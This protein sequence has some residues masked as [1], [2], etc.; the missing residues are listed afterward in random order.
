MA[1]EE[2][3]DGTGNEQ[4]AIEL[5]RKEEEGDGGGEGGGAGEEQTLSAA[6]ATALRA[7]LATAQQRTEQL[8]AL[9]GD[10]DVAAVLDAKN[11]G[12]GLVLRLGEQEGEDDESAAPKLPDALEIDAM[13]PSQTVAMILKQLPALLTHAVR[14]P[15]SELSERLGALETE[16]TTERKTKLKGDVEKLITRYPDFMTHKD[17]IEKLCSESGLTLN[18]AYIVARQ[19]SGKGFPEAAG[20]GSERPTAI[21]VRTPKKVAPARLGARGFKIDLREVLDGIEEPA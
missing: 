18:E 2:T 9:V 4:R 17:T 20:A 5:E 10:P 16:R 8:S 3:F 19:R 12:A 13:S 21:T 15:T 7:E 6:D 1:E 14:E 11:K